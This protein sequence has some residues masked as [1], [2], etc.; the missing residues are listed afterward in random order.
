MGLVSNKWLNL[1]PK[2]QKLFKKLKRVPLFSII[3][4][5]CVACSSPR[6][7]TVSAESLG[8]KSCGEC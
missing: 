7:A 8:M 1:S 4:I 5:H 6:A 3:C 2:E